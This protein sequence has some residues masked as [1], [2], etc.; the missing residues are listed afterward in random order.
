MILKGA[1]SDKCKKCGQRLYEMEKI[2]ANHSSYH[3]K[4]FQCYRCQR[5]LRSNSISLAYIIHSFIQAISI[6]PL[7]VHY[8]IEA[9]LTKHGYCAGNSC[10]SATGNCEW[11]IAQGPF[12]AARAGVEPMTLRTKGVDSTNAP[13]TP[14]IMAVSYSLNAQVQQHNTAQ[15]IQCELIYILLNALWHYVSP[16]KLLTIALL[17]YAV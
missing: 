6:A 2:N 16:L 4:C 5:Q 12:V 17:V 14:H 10:L 1:G 13:H 11:R 15:Q 3:R 7:Q 8:Y 9:L